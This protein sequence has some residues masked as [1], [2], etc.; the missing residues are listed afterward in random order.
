MSEETEI[1]IHVNSR[2]NPLLYK[3]L[4]RIKADLSLATWPQVLQSLIDRPSLR[5]A[6]RND[7]L[8][9]LYDLGLIERRRE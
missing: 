6:V 7:M 9:T 3:E 1:I 4:I 5:R 8:E 2:V